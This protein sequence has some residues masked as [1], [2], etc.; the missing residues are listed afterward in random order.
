MPYS[1]PFLARMRAAW[2]AGF[3]HNGNR[4]LYTV[5]GWNS[6]PEY[7]NFYEKYRR[8]GI[9]KR[10]INAPVNALWSDPPNVEGDET[11][12]KAWSD[13]I[14]SQPVYHS[15]ARLDK[16]AGL[17]RFAIM[18]IGYDGGGGLDTH[19]T[20]KEGRKVLYFQPYG[21]GS[22]RIDKYDQNQNSARY[23][24][25]EMYLVDPGNFDTEGRTIQAT[26]RTPLK[27]FKVHWTRVLH[28]A[29]NCLESPVFGA[30]RLEPIYNDLDDLMKITGGAA[31]TYWLA[32]NRGLHVDIDKEMDID[33]DDQAALAD[34]IEE[35]Q[36][37]LRRVLRTRGVSVK[38][39][40]SDVADPSQPF[41]VTLS[42]VAAATGI[43]KRVLMG[44]EAGQLA[45]QQDRANWAIQVDERISEYGQPIILIP[46]IRLMIDAGVLPAP[47]TLTIKWPDAFK[48]NPLERAQTSAQMARSAANLSKTL[49]T[50]EELNQ[51][52]ARA[53]LPTIVPVGGGNPFQANAEGAKARSPKKP[54]TEGGSKDTS[55]MTE[56]IEQPPL[57]KKRP[58]VVLLTPEE[59]REIIG[60]GK[61]PPVFDEKSDSHAKVGNDLKE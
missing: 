7:R 28:V 16:L 9:A 56:T 20:R 3:T 38:P 48:M 52:M 42:S 4:D 1:I 40:G 55:D 22:V 18:V 2:Q 51:S 36:H 49:A 53:A 11:F 32:G 27:A 61:H 39:L 44:S 46:F 25:P 60:F 13:L 14:A 31:E 34:E 29:E 54:P 58:E 15:L 45:S 33:P 8:Q 6:K 41:D 21:E 19:I 23:G 24:L 10:V 37:E 35:Y 5:F 43:P 57:M 50:I 30:S 26:T 17:G 59:C 47:S 12:N